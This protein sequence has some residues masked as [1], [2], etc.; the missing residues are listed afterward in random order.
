MRERVP[1]GEK[2][3]IG[4]RKMRY[5]VYACG[6]SEHPDLDY[7]TDELPADLSTKYP[8]ISVALLEPVS[9][10]RM[11]EALKSPFIGP[12]VENL[13]ILQIKRKDHGLLR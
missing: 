9:Y 1:L 7:D 3:V 8:Y 5:H 10:E 11:L 4:D 12:A 6:S 2:T 13:T